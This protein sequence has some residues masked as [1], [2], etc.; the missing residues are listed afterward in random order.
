MLYTRGEKMMSKLSIRHIG[1]VVGAY[2]AKSAYRPEQTDFLAF[3]AEILLGSIL[4][5]SVLFLVATLL[6]ETIIV[7][8]LL[9]VT[10]VVR[11][12]SGGAHCTAYY[13][14]LITSISVLIV[15]GYIIKNS[16]P[17]LSLL[18]SIVSIA[19]IALSVCIYWRYSPQAPPNKPFKDAAAKF[20]FRRYSL[21]AVVVL[22][23]IA[24]ILGTSSISAWT[25]VFSLLWQAFTLTAIG[26]SFISF[27]D[28][29]LT[30]KKEVKENAEFF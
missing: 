24:L 16:F 15:L 8:I 17:Y 12:L 11:I 27:L 10:G 22:S 13:R 20:A 6:G 4:K 23:T 3:G 30:P 19:I 18:P 7:A 1:Q 14:C 9:G 29:L 28:I 21:I 5:L 26:H 25:I 2:V